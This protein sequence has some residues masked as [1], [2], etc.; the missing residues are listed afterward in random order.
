MILRLA[1]RNWRAFDELDLE[2]GPGATF[3]VASNGVGKTSLMMA[4]A[5]GIF[6][7]ASGID[8]SSERRGDSQTT[9]VEVTLKLPTAGEVAI[10]RSIDERSR[11][12]LEARVGDETI[13]SQE[14]L[15]A[16]LVQEMGAELPILAR[17]TFMSH[18]GS[19][20]S[21]DGE[22]RLRDHLATV[23]GVTP[24][25]EAARSAESQAADAASALRKV[26]ATRRV[27]T[28]ERD[29]LLADLARVDQELLVLGS[30]RDVAVSR[31][32][33]AD[34]WRRLAEGWTAYRSAVSTRE[35]QLSALIRSGKS[36]LTEGISDEGDI[37]EALT[38][39]E[40]TLK[41]KVAYMESQLAETRARLALTEEV[42]A[43][44]QKANAVCP[45]CLR[46]MSDAETAAAH[47]EHGR[48]LAQLGSVVSDEEAALMNQRA[49]LARLTAI[50]SQVRSLPQPVRPVQRE[51]TATD[52]AT[53]RTAYERTRD[54]LLELDKVI[55]LR[56][57][58]R[59]SV[60]VAIRSLEEDA[61]RTGEV[62]S[63]LRREAVAR[64]AA[65]TFMATADEI[66]EAR[67]EP[68]VA[69]VGG[70][71]K[72]IFGT[73]GLRL[74]PNGEITREV[75]SRVLPFAALSGG[76]KIW[77]LLLVRLLITSA[78]TR[79]PFVWLDEPLEHL[80]PR[81]RSVVAGTLARASQSGGLRQVVVTT[82]EAE[83]ARQLM[84]DVP[85]ASLVYVRS[86][87]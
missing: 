6:G 1:L 37:L 21:E 3:V 39:T 15:Q 70:R 59:G 68:L 53:A 26:K 72:R 9:T 40:R 86:S 11:P 62:S 23:F 4:A 29:T 13:E 35:E 17:L 61:K 27:E 31:L 49:L 85:S 76:E 65:E 22:F 60:V 87:I 81:V 51:L 78:S 48:R 44:L 66:T 43:Q 25:L 73:D 12:L 41:E 75:G 20:E 50:V 46:P 84:E 71:W 38:A 8:P 69:E 52:E 57:A 55:G 18:G 54:D 63:L 80:D 16:L 36:L 10:R 42:A 5:W 24:I 30:R 2:L 7:E 32:K 28:R 33:E 14:R 82:Y 19:L 64:A 45:T 74:S 77:A 47:T 58:A 56:T 34:D 83:L 67:I 79:A